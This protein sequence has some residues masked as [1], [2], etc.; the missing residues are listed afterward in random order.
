M[1]CLA[2]DT[3]QEINTGFHLYFVVPYIRYGI[4][5]GRL[6][7]GLPDEP[8]GLVKKVVL[9]FCNGNLGFVAPVVPAA[10]YVAGVARLVSPQVT[11]LVYLY[12]IMAPLG[13]KACIAGDVPRGKGGEYG[14]DPGLQ[15]A[16][17]CWR[18]RYGGQQP[19]GNLGRATMQFLVR[20]RPARKIPRQIKI[21]QNPRRSVP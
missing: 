12:N 5:Y 9:V 13:Q 6:R 14:A 16:L 4:F 11:I 15:G 21:A 18:A 1:A 3:T 19:I 10:I 20:Q 7:L 17:S 2:I 8:S